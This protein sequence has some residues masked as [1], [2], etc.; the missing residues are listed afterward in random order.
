MLILFQYGFFHLYNTERWTEDLTLAKNSSPPASVADCWDY[1]CASHTWSYFELPTWDGLSS[2][3]WWFS[4]GHSSSFHLILMENYSKAS[5]L[6][7][8]LRLSACHCF[9]ISLHTRP[10]FCFMVSMH[11]AFYSGCGES[12]HSPQFLFSFSWCRGW[13]NG[14]RRDTQVAVC[15]CSSGSWHK[16]NRMMARWSESR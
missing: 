15:K 4:Q 1:K 14:G 3:K 13:G 7:W 11:G 5:V 12:V 8:N 10:A 9:L 16:S 2:G 6:M